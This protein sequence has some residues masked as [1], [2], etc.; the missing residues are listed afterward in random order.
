[1]SGD[2]NVF[3]G[4]LCAQNAGAAG[5]NLFIGT[6]SGLACSTGCNN[7]VLG[8]YADIQ[9]GT[10]VGT[11][12]I[13]Y[14][15]K[16]GPMYAMSLGAYASADGNQALAI[17]YGTRVV[18]DGNFNIADRL[19]GYF[20]TGSTAQN[21]TYSVQ[22]DADQV[23]VAGALGM[24]H[25]D[26]GS[27]AS[28]QWLAYLEPQRNGFADLVLRSANNAVVR[29][30]DEFYP[31]IFDFT[32]QH[33]CFFSAGGAVREGTD[34]VG[35][36]VVASGRYRDLQGRRNVIHIDEALPEVELSDRACD[37][38]VFGVISRFENDTQNTRE[39]QLGNLA[40]GVPSVDT[41]VIV[42]A[43]GEGCIWVCDAAGPLRNGDLIVSSHVAGYGM[44]Q[45]DDII[46]SCTIAKVTCDCDFETAGVVHHG[47]DGGRYRVVRVGCTYK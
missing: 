8:T 25:R 4:M 29:F 5:G 3:L 46:R 1:M 24:C 28:P 34:L 47:R 43:A 11:V 12:A 7:V 41:R 31:S 33:R 44:R 2:E 37:P 27:N 14:A 15:A 35:C 36:I 13:G 19:R 30:T 9:V 17:G 26:S 32:G 38:R 6:R 20:A 18:G 16:A 10:D 39:Y 42:N 23:K 21:D 45:T 40:F 22:I